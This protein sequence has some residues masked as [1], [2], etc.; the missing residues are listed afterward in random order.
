M[1]SNE[2]KIEVVL[3]IFSGR[4]NPKWTLSI[5]QV[6]ELKTKLGKFPT[7]QPKMPPGLGYRG[8][9]ITNLSKA[10]SIPERIIAYNGVLSIT[11]KGVT[12]YREDVNNIEKWGLNQAREQGYREIVKQL[13]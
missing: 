13:R 4:P 6:E 10:P 2:L 5:E 9:T 1:R 8:I 3:D 12:T 7:A 11:D